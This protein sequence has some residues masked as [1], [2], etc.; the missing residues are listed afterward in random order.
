MRGDPSGQ[1]D[2]AC[3]LIANSCPFAGKPTDAH[4]LSEN[5]KED[6][7]SMGASAVASIVS[8]DTPTGIPVISSSRVTI[9]GDDIYYF[10]RLSL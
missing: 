5:T 10:A 3:R 7:W 1:G 2:G 8:W 4:N 6:G 9:Y